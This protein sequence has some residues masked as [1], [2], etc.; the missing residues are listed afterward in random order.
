MKFEGSFAE[1]N[2]LAEEFER[3][4]VKAQKLIQHLEKEGKPVSTQ[5]R[6]ALK[7]K[8]PRVLYNSLNKQHYLLG[9][10]L[11]LVTRFLE[12]VKDQ[13]RTYSQGEICTEIKRLRQEIRR[14]MDELER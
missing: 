8:N 14:D 12:L 1:L 6:Y 2:P 11:D 3:S 13:G 10:A 9:N 4:A 7:N 5:N